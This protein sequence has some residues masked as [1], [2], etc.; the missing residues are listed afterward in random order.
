[1]E[2]RLMISLCAAWRPS[3]TTERAATTVSLTAERASENTMSGSKSSPLAPAIE[4]SSSATVKKS[5][6]APA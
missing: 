2:K 1:M 3:L 4:G 5:A 6:N